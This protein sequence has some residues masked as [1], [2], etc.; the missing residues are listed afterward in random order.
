MRLYVCG[1]TTPDGD[2][3]EQ[4]VASDNRGQ[5]DPGRVPAHVLDWAWRF[6]GTLPEGT[7]YRVGLFSPLVLGAA[8]DRHVRSIAHATW[9]YDSVNQ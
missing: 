2:Y 6:A 3:T 4:V 1:F 7:T 8:A 9:L 5:R